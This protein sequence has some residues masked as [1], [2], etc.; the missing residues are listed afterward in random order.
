VCLIFFPQ[1]RFRV[2]LI[3]SAL[4][5]CAAVALGGSREERAS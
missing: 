5:I 1:D 4:V 2:P 3:D